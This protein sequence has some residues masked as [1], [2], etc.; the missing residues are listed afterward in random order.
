MEAV[1]QPICQSAPK[2]FLMSKVDTSQLLLEIWQ[3]FIKLLI[4]QEYDFV[5]VHAF[6]ADGW[7]LQ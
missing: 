5:C 7:T 3:I 6:S 1:E 2:S 4:V